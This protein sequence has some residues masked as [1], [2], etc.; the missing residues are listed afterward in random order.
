MNIFASPTCPPGQE[1]LDILLKQ[2]GVRIERIVSRGYASPPGDWY[3]Q[4]EDEWVCVLT[5]CATLQVGEQFVT[6]EAGDGYY[7]PAHRKHRVHAT[8]REPDCVWLCVFWEAQA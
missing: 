5:G 3:D 1:Q 7:L 4:A 2:P 8:S 6:L